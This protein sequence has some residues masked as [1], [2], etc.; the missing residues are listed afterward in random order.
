MVETLGAPVE[1]KYQ[2]SLSIPCVLKKLFKVKV[3]IFG[4]FEFF[5]KT[6]SFIENIAQTKVVDHKIVYKNV[7]HIFLPK[8]HNY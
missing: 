1:I 6:V 5:L 8:N 3:K 4:I 2:K 7:P